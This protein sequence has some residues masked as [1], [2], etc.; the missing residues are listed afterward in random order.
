MVKTFYSKTLQITCF[1]YALSLT[2]EVRKYFS[3][4]DKLVSSQKSCCENPILPL[5]VEPIIT[6]LRTWFNADI[7]YCET[8]KTIRKF[9]NQ[10]NPDDEMAEDFLS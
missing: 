6:H 5:S 1:A 4:V 10:L 9:T 3:N 8:I 7:Y 2:V